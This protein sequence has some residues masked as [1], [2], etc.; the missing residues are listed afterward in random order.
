VKDILNADTAKT[1]SK[2]QLQ[3]LIEATDQIKAAWQQ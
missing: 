1:Y 3:Q 2:E